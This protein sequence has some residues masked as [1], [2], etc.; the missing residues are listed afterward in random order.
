MNLKPTTIPR[1]QLAQ[2][3]DMLPMN[4]REALTSERNS[5]I[6]WK[7]CTD[8]HLS[9]E[10]TR[11][12]ARIAAWVMMG[13]LHPSDVANEVKLSIGIHPELAATIANTLNAKI[14]APMREELE[15]TYAPPGTEPH[16]QESAAVATLEDI[17]PPE[18][19]EQ[20]LA[21]ISKG[22]PSE[23]FFKETPVTLEALKEQGTRSKEQGE[24]FEIPPAFEMPPPPPGGITNY[25][26]PITNAD[27]PPA[28]PDSLTPKTSNLEPTPFILHEEA[29]TPSLSQVG[30]FSLDIKP[31][32]FGPSQ[33][34]FEVIPQ[35][36][37][38]I[39]GAQAEGTRNKEQ[40]TSGEGDKS[41]RTVHYGDLRTPIENSLE[42]GGEKIKGDTS[43]EALD[44][45][46]FG[47]PSVPAEP[48]AEPPPPPPPPRK[49][50]EPAEGQKKPGFFARFL[51]KKGH[52]EVKPPETETGGLTSVTFAPEP[53]APPPPPS[54]S[55]T[56]PSPNDDIIN[57]DSLNV[58]E[59]APLKP[60]T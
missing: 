1:K 55:P 51:G 3:W 14:F 25:Q 18:V 5:D 33:P 48:E 60:K 58:S 41:Q 32:E 40:G 21:N 50:S 45:S 9:E 44:F 42:V 35:A 22:A 11:E 20:T 30:D 26:L 53:D 43:S 13:F 15:G 37:I 24:A 8:E 46:S 56:P 19:V 31:E 16:Y 59:G 49:V 57:L 54:L 36:N 38:E 12:V 17:R 27:I 7:V 2:R 39:G 47:S 28:P 34:E 29:P 23:P 4:L 10:K 6:L 52:T